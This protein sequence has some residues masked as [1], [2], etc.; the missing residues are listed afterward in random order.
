MATTSYWNTEISYWSSTYGKLFLY[1]LSFWVCYHHSFSVLVVQT[2]CQIHQLYYSESFLFTHFFP[3]LIDSKFMASC[4][5]KNS[6]SAFPLL[7]KLP[8]S[9][10]LQS[11]QTLMYLNSKVLIDHLLS[12]LK[13]LLWLSKD[14]SIKPKLVCKTNKAHFWECGAPHSKGSRRNPV[15]LYVQ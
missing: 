9:S 11:Q 2:W 7:L 8:F 12:Y 4:N 5:L 3:C 14:L 6:F 10:P 15:H 1:L 13:I